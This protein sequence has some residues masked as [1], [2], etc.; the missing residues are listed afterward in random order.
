M[1]H[2]S[3]SGDLLSAAF[4][5]L[6]KGVKPDVLSFWAPEQNGVVQNDFLC[7]GRAAKSPVLAHRFLDFVLDEKNAY[8]ELRQLHRLHAAAERDRRARR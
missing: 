5:Y 1:L 7:I 6:P 2:H 8:V 4:Y 3:W